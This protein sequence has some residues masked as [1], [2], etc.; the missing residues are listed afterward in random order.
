MDIEDEEPDPILVVRCQVSK[1]Q[2]NVFE[3]PI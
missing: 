3:M 1:D 2:A